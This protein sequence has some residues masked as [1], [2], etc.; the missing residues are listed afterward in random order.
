[1]SNKKKGFLLTFLVDLAIMPQI[2]RKGNT[3][4]CV[5]DLFWRHSFFFATNWPICPVITDKANMENKSKTYTAEQAAAR[6]GVA[7]RTLRRWAGN[8]RIERIKTGG[9]VYYRIP[10]Q[11]IADNLANLDSLDTLTGQG[12][13]VTGQ[14]TRL[15]DQGQVVTGQAVSQD[16]QDNNG[17]IVLRDAFQGSAAMVRQLQQDNREIKELHK[18]QLFSWRL[19]AGIACVT[20]MVLS[21]IVFLGYGLFVG[22]GGELTRLENSLVVAIQQADQAN[23]QID[24]ADDRVARARDRADLAE[25]RAEQLKAEQKAKDSQ[26]RTFWDWWD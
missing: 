19:T 14:V 3:V 7:C 10:E 22:R 21:S 18:K 20:A 26:L 1:M 8:G 24:R 16:A 4:S 6:L 17:F 5:A 23:R 13:I 11:L 15:S 25:K 2:V 12:R 9:K